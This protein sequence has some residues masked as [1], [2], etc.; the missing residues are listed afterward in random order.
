MTIIYPARHKITSRM[1]TRHYD[2][3]DVTKRA[4]N[5]VKARDVRPPE[6]T[7]GIISV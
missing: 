4:V 3:N 5:I 2:V 1:F 7:V 6:S